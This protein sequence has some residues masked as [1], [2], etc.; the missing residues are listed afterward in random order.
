MQWTQIKTLFIFSFLI[1][2]LFL[3]TQLLSKQQEADL[4][5]MERNNT[6]I[7]QQLEDENIE[8][9]AS[10]EENGDKDKLEENYIAVGQKNLG[11]KEKSELKAL[12]NQTPQIIGNN[13]IVSNFKD[14][15]KIPEDGS[16]ENIS[17]LFGQLFLYP[18][19]Y[20]FWNWNKEMNVLLFFQEKSDRP[21]YYNQSGIVMVFL[22]DDNEMTFYVQTLLGDA[23][24]SGSEKQ[25]I[26]P[27][28]AIEELYKAK[29]LYPDDEVTK[30]D[31]GF[32]TMVP[33]P[34][35]IQSFAPSW[36]VTVNDKKHFFVN[37]IEGRIFF[38]DELQFLE[39]TIM[40]MRDKI[41]ESDMDQK[42][43]EKIIAQLEEKLDTSE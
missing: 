36:K 4:E 29:E 13:V 42:E 22:N 26:T 12:D 30:V 10:L 11:D 5:V 21:V 16:E 6:T 17:A 38:S 8:I 20:T 37:A 28:T 41:L 32:H 19:Q 23:E 7:E 3:L 40:S 39:D 24:K 14:P 1:L 18:E 31:I 33:L 27:L 35:G 25:L 9:T 15:I 34:N 2:D 43:K